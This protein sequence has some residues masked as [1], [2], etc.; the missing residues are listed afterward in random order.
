MN[1]A[2]IYE[3]E[4]REYLPI[5]YKGL[6]FK[7]LPVKRFALY[8]NAKAASCCCPPCRFGLCASAGFRLWTRWT[9]RQTRC[10]CDPAI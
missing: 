4:L 9:G 3:D 8:Q 7:P 6:L 5:A 2:Q 1:V 10:R